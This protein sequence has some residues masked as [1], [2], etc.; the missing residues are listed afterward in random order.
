MR[1]FWTCRLGVGIECG[2]HGVACRDVDI[3]G[4][5]SGVVAHNI[6]RGFRN[7]N[8]KDEVRWVSRHGMTS[9]IDLS[10]GDQASYE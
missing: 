4:H 9:N 10:E 7:P 3:E 1:D 5:F 8:P 2:P 6:K